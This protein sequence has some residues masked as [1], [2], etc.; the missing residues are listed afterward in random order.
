M[1]INH[2]NSSSDVRHRHVW[3]ENIAGSSLLSLLK[4]SI[5]EQVYLEHLNS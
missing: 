2:L 3:H 4:D 1:A 5:I